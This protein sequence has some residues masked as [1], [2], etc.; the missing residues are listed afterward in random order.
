MCVTSWFDRE[1]NERNAQESDGLLVI[2]MYT[3]RRQLIRQRSAKSGERDKGKASPS[4]TYIQLVGLHTRNKL[5]YRKNPF[6]EV[7]FLEKRKKKE[8]WTTCG[9]DLGVV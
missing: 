8:L 4:Y 7:R 2:L 5:V 6:Q 3:H 1:G 9:V